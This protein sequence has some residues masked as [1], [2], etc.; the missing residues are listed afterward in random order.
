MIVSIRKISKF[1][2]FKARKFDSSP[3]HSSNCFSGERVCL[4]AV[5]SASH[6]ADDDDGSRCIRASTTL[7]LLAWLGRLA[8]RSS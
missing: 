8:S 3:R 2:P 5:P 7:D 1:P 6:F 4:T